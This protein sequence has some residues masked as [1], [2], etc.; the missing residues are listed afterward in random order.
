MTGGITK[1]NRNI[2][3]TLIM[4]TDDLPIRSAYT[5]ELQQQI[6]KELEKWAEENSSQINHQ[7][8]KPMNFRKGGKQ[9]TK[10]ILILLGEPLED[11]Q[12]FKYLGITLQTLTL[13]RFHITRKSSCWN[14]ALKI[15][16]T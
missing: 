14:T 16:T 13:F 9:T 4:Y 10:D 12:Y 1:I 8:T 11:V 2:S 5:K 7:K 3:A 15:S 6:L